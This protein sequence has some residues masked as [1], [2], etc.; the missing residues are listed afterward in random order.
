MAADGSIH[1]LSFRRQAEIIVGKF[2]LVDTKL[3]I[4]Y[5]LAGV[6]DRSY[7]HH[8]SNGAIER[9]RK[10]APELLTTNGV[11]HRG[12]YSEMGLRI[13]HV[14]PTEVVYQHFKSLFDAG[15][16][17]VGYVERTIRERLFCALITEEE[18]DLLSQAGLRKRMPQA[19]DFDA[20]DI[21][22]RYRIVNL[23]MKEF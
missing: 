17:T 21:F 9:L 8:I 20:G 15:G 11:S 2:K 4:K 1:E 18:D 13:E 12:S 14:I 16:L 5:T 6:A 19:W 10:E 7:H 22:A 3:S 23:Q